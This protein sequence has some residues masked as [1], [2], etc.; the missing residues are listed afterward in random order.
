[1]SAPDWLATNRSL[2]NGWTRL[3]E[4]SPFYDVDAFRRG[5]STLGPV[6]RALVGDVAGRTLLHPQ[7]HFGLD[8]ISWARL[9]A[10]AVG[11]DLSDEAIALA[12]RL[13]DDE[14][15][16]A[17]FVRANIYDLP[18]ALP[19]DVPRRY[20]VV[21]SSYGVKAW[22]PDVAAW[23]R[24]IAACLAPGGAF[25]LIEFHPLVEALAADGRTIVDH[26]FDVGPIRA[27]GRGSY[28][29]PHA[30][31]EHESVQWAHS[32][33]EIVTALIDAGLRIASLREYPFSTHGHLPFTVER[34][35]GEW[36]VRDGPAVP[37][38]FSVSAVAR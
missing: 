33:G 11:G 16:D 7:C 12:R 21:F 10:R 22:L 29:E 18:D 26:Y 27:A 38:M 9:G 30:P 8:T 3:H 24:V 28:A 31:F 5:A 37:M 34:A 17:R 25:H 23:A 13:A 6:E 1:M 20:D 14:G 35:P 36:V 19:D 32:I 15:S 2:W 4:R